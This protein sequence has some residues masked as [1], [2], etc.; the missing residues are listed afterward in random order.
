MRL[1]WPGDA[2]CGFSTSV[3]TSADR[4][5]RIP[6]SDRCGATCAGSMGQVWPEIGFAS[7]IIPQRGY[8]T[9]IP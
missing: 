5:C 8:E 7:L 1:P 6:F 2:V 9:F 4:Q 3:E